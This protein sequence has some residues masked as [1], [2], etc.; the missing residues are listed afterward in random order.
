MCRSCMVKIACIGLYLEYR[1]PVYTQEMLEE[2]CDDQL[3]SPAW[4]IRLEDIQFS[5]EQPYHDD[6]SPSGMGEVL[7]GMPKLPVALRMHR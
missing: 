5:K 2:W 4:C 6:T 1:A 3:Y 7:Y